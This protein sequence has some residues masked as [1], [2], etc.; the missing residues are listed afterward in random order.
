VDVRSA[1]RLLPQALLIVALLFAWMGTGDSP[2]RRYSLDASAQGYVDDGLK[3]ALVTFATAR[4]LNAV[5]SLAQGT[6]VSVQPLGVGV[7]VSIGQVLRP[8]NEVV[9]QFAELMLIAS[10]AFGAMEILIRVGGHWTVT[11]ALTIVAVWYLRLRSRGTASP[12]ILVKLLAVLLFVRF[13]IP[14][15]SIGS[16]AIYRTFMA[17]DY[18]ASQEAIELSTGRI[19]SEVPHQPGLQDPNK[20]R[21]CGPLPDWLCRKLVGG[22]GEAPKAEPRADGGA[23]ESGKGAA[24]V[25]APGR[26]EKLRNMAENIAEHIVRLMAVFVL[27]TMVLPLLLV[28]VLLRGMGVL[29]HRS[30]P[31]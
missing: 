9:G 22:S 2:V 19:G 18:K 21:D 31:R 14:A 7:Q 29:L 1:R 25:D 30:A 20:G 8:I 16:D 12:A 3:R 4:A 15:V 11:L 24:L 26:I 6:Q 23:V 10:I 28:W 13:A 27:Q 17:G 5:L